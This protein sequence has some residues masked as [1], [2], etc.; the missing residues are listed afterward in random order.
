MQILTMPWCFEQT[1][2]PVIGP[3]CRLHNA[4]SEIA[5][6]VV[7]PASLLLPKVKG[8]DQALIAG[9]STVSGSMHS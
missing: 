5:Y 6:E 2:L 9:L 8:L 1:S 7:Q 4:A 3:P